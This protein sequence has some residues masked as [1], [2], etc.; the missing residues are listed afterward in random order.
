MYSSNL[1]P[2]TLEVD[3]RLLWVHIVDG[4]VVKSKSYPVY[5]K[6]ILKLEKLKVDEGLA[7]YMLFA[8]VAV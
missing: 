2:D 3:R 1:R 6:G 5:W 4:V 8:A 7:W